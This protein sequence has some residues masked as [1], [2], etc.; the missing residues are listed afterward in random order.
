[1]IIKQKAGSFLQRGAS[2]IVLVLMVSYALF[3]LYH[4]V[5]WL[6]N[7]YPNE[8]REG[9]SLYLVHLLAKGVNPFSAESPDSFF[10][11]YGF[12]SSWVIA[13][14]QKLLGENVFFLHR[15]FSLICI[16]LTAGLVEAEVRRGSLKKF[17]KWLGFLLML[18][19][20]WILHEL[21]A[22]PDHFAL[23]LF[24]FAT[25][26]LLRSSRPQ[27]ATLAACCI[28]LAFYTKQY[29]VL[30]SVPLFVGMLFINLRQAL[31]FG[32]TFAV[33]FIASLFAVQWAYPFYFPMAFL[34]FGGQ[35]SSGGGGIGFLIR[36]G[37]FF[38][39]FYWPLILMIFLVGIVFLRRTALGI[40]WAKNFNA[41]LVKVWYKDGTDSGA[42]GMIFFLA[43]LFLV[44]G[45]FLCWIGQNDGAF[46]SY[47]YQ[48]L[49][50]PAVMLS[51][52]LFGSVQIQRG[53]TVLFLLSVCVFS[54]WHIKGAASFTKPLT[55]QE[56]SDWQ[57]AEVLVDQAGAD[58]YLKSPLF[59]KYALKNSVECFY[60]GLYA[61]KW[62]GSSYECL[63]E[64]NAPLIYLFP[65]APDVIRRCEAYLQHCDVSLKK[66]EFDLVVTGAAAPA[67]KDNLAAAGYQRIREM[68]LRTGG[69]TWGVEF[70]MPVE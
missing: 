55:A 66:R 47:F 5:V 62:L 20:G 17:P 56:K 2:W 27:A 45:L 37:A 39:V 29:F 53:L 44:N 30:V 49:L 1:M 34:A 28:V 21:N 40:G 11:M 14:L 3:A 58:I 18:P 57:E 7:P 19:A 64:N 33:L 13:G 6:V 67:E 41:P 60:G 4:Y 23:L 35:G 52:A 38:G 46:L 42:L 26:L 68:R 69:Q 15:L 43:V 63:K 16:L 70:W 36:Q 48:L 54:M 59:V 61:N 24:A 50:L 8:Y 22:R 65:A 10:Y 51:A 32:F 9:I 25:V 31:V 12:L